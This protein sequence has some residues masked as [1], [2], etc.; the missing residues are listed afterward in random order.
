M[1]YRRHTKAREVPASERFPEG[2]AD[3][4]GATY[5]D[6]TAQ[7]SLQGVKPDSEQATAE[8]KRKRSVKSDDKSGD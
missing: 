6:T 5:A 7:L 2:T 4:E 8:P 1:L 3:A